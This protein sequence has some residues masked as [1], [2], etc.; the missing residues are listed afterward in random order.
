MPLLSIFTC[1]RR[2]ID[3]NLCFLSKEIKYIVKIEGG[4]AIRM[5]CAQAVGDGGSGAQSLH[6]ILHKTRVCAAFLK[7]KLFSILVAYKL[8]WGREARR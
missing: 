7:K 3:G 8:V 1:E 6:K 4:M 5:L 2:A